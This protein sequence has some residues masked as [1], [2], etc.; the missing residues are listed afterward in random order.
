MRN[1]YFNL[2]KLREFYEEKKKSL[3]KQDNKIQIS[4][5]NKRKLF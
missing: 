2:S 4:N 3:L 5:F 1:R